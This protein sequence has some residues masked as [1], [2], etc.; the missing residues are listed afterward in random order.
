MMKHYLLITE[1]VINYFG[2][3]NSY[4]LEF[5]MSYKITREM[6]P[7]KCFTSSASTVSHNVCFVKNL[8][9][10]CLQSLKKQDK[11]LQSYD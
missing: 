8:I 7:K 1:N 6:P 10:P 2:N 5:H 3:Y 9:K 11:Q 4:I